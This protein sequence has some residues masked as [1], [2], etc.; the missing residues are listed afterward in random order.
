MFNQWMKQTTYSC[1]IILIMLHTVS[2]GKGAREL[3][4][5][6]FSLL[7]PFSVAFAIDLSWLALL[8]LGISLL[9][10]YPL[11]LIEGD[12]RAED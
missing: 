9:K 3:L 4:N 7:F 11:I 8:V 6:F 12:E 2:M 1:P 10:D 5:L